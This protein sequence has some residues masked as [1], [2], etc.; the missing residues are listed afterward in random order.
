[1]KPS[2]NGG[3][4]LL[5]RRSL[6]YVR[7]PH[8]RHG[9][10]GRVSNSAKSDTLKDFLTFVDTN[11]QPNGR[12]TESYCPTHYFLS[13]FTTIQTPKT[14]VKNYDQ[15]CSTSLAGEFNRIQREQNKPTISN[16]SVST[17]LKKHRPKYAVCPHK[18]DYCDTCAGLKIRFKA[19]KCV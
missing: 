2:A 1:M 4:I 6:M 17:W 19:P 14:T 13:K 3:D 9:L 15:R 7:Y 12:T 8:E 16:Y 10:A 5:Q 18:L 11:S